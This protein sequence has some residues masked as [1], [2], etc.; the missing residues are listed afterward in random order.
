[1]KYFPWAA[2]VIL[3][4]GFW[5]WGQE[6]Q[7]SGQYKERIAQLESRKAHVDTFYKTVYKTLEKTRRVTD[8]LIV[9]DTLTFTDT[10][11]QVIYAERRACNAVIETCEQRV[12]VRDS[13][14]TV[15][16]KKPSPIKKV[17][18]IVGGILIGK[19]LLH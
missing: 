17:P 12:A 13:I 2:W 4:I 7:R 10:V 15:L 11:T 6:R 9:T 1:M 16:K 3:I 5:L 18:W 19:F 14:I 8:S